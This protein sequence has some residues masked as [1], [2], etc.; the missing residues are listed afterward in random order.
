M[1]CKCQIVR[2]LPTGKKRF[3]DLGPPPVALTDLNIGRYVNSTVNTVG[4]L[5]LNTVSILEI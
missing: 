4:K 2:G 1:V 5:K 3:F